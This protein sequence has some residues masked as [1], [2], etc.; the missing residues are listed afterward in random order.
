MDGKC[1]GLGLD[2]AKLNFL[3]DSFVGVTPPAPFPFAGGSCRSDD[4]P[5]AWPEE[6]EVSNNNH[7]RFQMNRAD[8]TGD[9]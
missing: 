6:A 1:I 8:A 9:S 5:R 4:F 3:R 2:L 7:A